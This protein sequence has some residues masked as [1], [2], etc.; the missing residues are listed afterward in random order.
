[1]SR[2]NK[3]LR[4]LA[5][6]ED[7]EKVDDSLKGVPRLRVVARVALR[8]WWAYAILFL[9]SGVMVMS[10]GM[11]IYHRTEMPQ[12]C[13]GCHE[14]Q[15]NYDSWEFSAHK[16]IKCV[17]CHATPGLMGYLE[18]KLSGVKQLVTH[19]TAD[20]IDDIHLGEH[21]KEIVSDNCQRCHPGVVRVDERYGLNISH[22]KHLDNGLMCVTCHSGRFAHPESEEMAKQGL[23]DMTECYGC[24]DGE[25][26][27]D[28]HTA[29]DAKNEANCQNCHP[30]SRLALEHGGNDPSVKSRKPC[31]DCHS[32]A[33]GHFIMDPD[34]E[35]ALCGNCHDLPD[36]IKAASAHKP[37]ADGKC[38]KCHT[39]MANSHLFGVGPKPSN[40]LC[41]SCH[42]TL[43]DIVNADNPEAV[44]AFSDGKS[45][46]HIGH[47]EYIGE[48]A[49]EDWCL[50]C[51]TPHASEMKKLIKLRKPDRTEEVAEPG[52]YTK[53]ENGGTCSGACH[54]GDEM[55][56]TR[57]SK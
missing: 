12:F 22:E 46:L 8:F 13:V 47:K 30:D 32:E 54:E 15:G 56:Y 17:D 6:P 41:F 53:T 38:N 40:T 36:A 10:A 27:I 50:A 23:A 2:F 19:I 29:F 34:N 39:V 57:A 31:L 28:G 33:E 18:V 21:H 55:E 51:H 5:R 25:S 24:H 1:M 26:T 52:V 16:G 14:M 48:E 42:K 35:K 7:K 45:D 11:D 49:E 43:S 20:S 3:L 4:K 44:S 37:Y 9:I